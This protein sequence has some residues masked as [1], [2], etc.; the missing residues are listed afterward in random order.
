MAI[1]MGTVLRC[2]L[3]F[4]NPSMAEATEIGGVMMPSAIRKAPPAM[5]GISSQCP[6]IAADQRIE[7]KDATLAF[8]IGLQGDDHIF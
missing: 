5:A 1:M 6:S 4:C 8:V 3:N 2:G 7:R